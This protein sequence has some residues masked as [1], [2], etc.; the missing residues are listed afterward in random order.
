MSTILASKKDRSSLS[1]ETFVCSRLLAVFKPHC[2]V[3]I[4]LSSV[5]HASVLTSGF[6]CHLTRIPKPSL[7]ESIFLQ[8]GNG[9]V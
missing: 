3:T 1:H 4:P 9:H 7:S 5:T 8:S 6:F 2:G